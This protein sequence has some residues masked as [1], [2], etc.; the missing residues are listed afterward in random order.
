[1]KKGIQFSILAGA[2]TIG[3]FAVNPSSIFANRSI[4]DDS[5][6]IGVISDL[7]LFPKELGG[8]Q[9][10]LFQEYLS[11]DRKM[12]IESERILD[13]AIER[14]LVEHPDIVLVP[15]DLTKD[16]ER[17]S[18]QMVAQKLQKLEDQGIE[19]FIINGNHDINNPDAVEFVTDENGVEKK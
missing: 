11:G 17:I 2:A 6:R 7:H 18:H 1:M 12:L 10:E 4:V 15:G 3:L 5:I 19:V 14:V 13:A 16:S 9:G 8:E